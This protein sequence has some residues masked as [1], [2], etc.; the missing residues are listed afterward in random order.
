METY[1]RYSLDSMATPL[2]VSYRRNG[3]N[4]GR[5]TGLRR[6]TR[7]VRAPEIQPVLTLRHNGEQMSICWVEVNSTPLRRVW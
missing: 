3:I 7:Q 2:P 1:C 5:V 6:W 4:I